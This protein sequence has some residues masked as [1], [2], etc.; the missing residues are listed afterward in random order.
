MDC[1]HLLYQSCEGVIPEDSLGDDIHIGPVITTVVV[2]L[3]HL[4]ISGMLT[5]WPLGD[6]NEI[7]KTWFSILFYWLVSYRS[8]HDNAFWWMWQDPAD[9]QSTLVQV[10]AW[11]RQATSHY[12]SQC[13]PSSMSPY[14][15]TRPQ[16]VNSSPPEQNGSHFVDDMF[17]RIF[18]NENIWISNKSSL[19]YVHWG[20]IGNMSALVQIK[21][22]RHPGAKPLSESMLTQFTG[23][24][25]RH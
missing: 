23:A 2:A 5:H 15:V 16:W 21:A 17:K 24:Y 4:I 8:S 14:G 11:C 18:L 3:C 7:L 25:M 20:P 6:L 22:W 1:C 10:M 13:W 12:L 19:K 9:H